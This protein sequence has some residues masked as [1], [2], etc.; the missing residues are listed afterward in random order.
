MKRLAIGVLLLSVLAL[1]G[2]DDDG[3]LVP[4]VELNQFLETKYD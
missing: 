2:C 4:A 3:D 1:V